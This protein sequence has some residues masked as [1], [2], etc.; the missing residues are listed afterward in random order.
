MDG[1]VEAAGAV[2]EA[3][4]GRPGRLFECCDLGLLG[5]LLDCVITA[6]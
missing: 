6:C 4:Y 2:F 1:R 3:N 5:V